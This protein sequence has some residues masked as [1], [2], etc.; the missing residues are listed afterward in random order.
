MCV[1]MSN[2]ELEKYRTKVYVQT[3]PNLVAQVDSFTKKVLLVRFF[4]WICL[5]NFTLTFWYST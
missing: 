4:I 1:T 5:I 2:Q 3:E